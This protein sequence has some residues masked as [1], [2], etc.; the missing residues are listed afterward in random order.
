MSKIDEKI[1][2]ALR[3]LS[4]D[5]VQKANSGHPGLPMGAAPMAYS[6]WSEHLNFSP[7]DKEWVNRDRFVLSPGHGS[8][9]LYS[10]LHIYGYQLPM[11]E[12][13][14]FRQLN[15]MTPGHPEY[16]HT[17][18]VETTTGPLGQ[19][20]AN[21]VGMAIAERYLAKKFNTD[22]FK[23]IDHH[24]YVIASDGDMMEGVCAEAASLAG[25]L[26]L[27]KIICLY[28]DNKITIDGSTDSTFLEDV[29]RRFESYGWYV[30]EVKDGTDIGKIKR[31]ISRAKKSEIPN[32][33]IVKT[34]IGHGS[35]NRQGTSK[36][37]GAP[38]GEEEV[39]LTRENLKW[40]YEPFEIPNEVYVQARKQ[41]AKKEKERAKWYKNLEKYKEKNPDLYKEY[42]AW[43]LNEKNFSDEEMEVLLSTSKT[44]IATRNAGGEIL[45]RLYEMVPNLMGGSAD[46]NES[47]KTYIKTA[48]DFHSEEIGANIF[49]GIR[50]HAMGA[51][52]NGITLHGGLKSF[53]STFLVFSDYMRSTIRLAALMKIPSVFVFTHD[54]IAVGEDGPTHQPVEHVMSLR[55]I[56]GLNVYRP[57][58]ARETAYAWASALSSKNEPSVLILTRQDLPVI[59]EVNKGANR[60]GY[61]LI[62]EPKENLD[63][64]LM[65]TGSEISILIE[66]QKILSF[67]GISARVVSIPNFKAFI[68]Q[69]DEYKNEVIPQNVPK[70]S[71]E[72]GITWG[73][74]RF[75]KGEGLSIGIDE[76]GASGKM[77]DVFE[78]YGITIEEV[79]KKA[80]ELVK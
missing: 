65:G 7:E 52:V 13:K 69:E 74:E 10:L 5:G 71:L 50:E 29:K 38:L 18:G 19:G 17:P 23:V 43:F 2:N 53:C 72:A 28:D 12:I 61:V 34:N 20:F 24:T 59:K 30:Q 6:I 63:L 80:R 47:T 75:V 14:K 36:A 4:I 41:V 26:E 62:K 37:H 8:M 16:G 21:A 32:L 40:D 46:L 9:L 45:N 3:F 48:G 1:I 35:P 77:K 51:I 76:F 79:A 44:S 25:T 57:A 64:V 31:A 60:G 66:V 22:D 78:H 58:D 54:S 39:K 33:I 27:E 56:P 67:E 42:E 73:W 49:F 11:D 55:M 15:S 70:L 68:E